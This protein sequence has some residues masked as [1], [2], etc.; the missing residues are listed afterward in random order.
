MR[1]IDNP[2]ESCCKWVKLSSFYAPYAALINASMTGKS[3][4]V[5][6]LGNHGVF[7]ML[8]CLRLDDHPNSNDRPPRTPFLADYEEVDRE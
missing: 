5:M 1:N 2:A 3:R 8:I 6:E 7:V 4:L